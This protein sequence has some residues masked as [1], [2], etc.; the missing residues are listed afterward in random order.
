M[1]ARAALAWI[2]R[3][4]VVL[5]A[6][7]G[8]APSLVEK[9]AGEPIRGSW[10]GHPKGKQI[11]RALEAIYDSGEVRAFRLIGGKVTLV[12]RRL[13]PHLARVAPGLAAERVAEIRQ[14]HTASGAHRTIATPFPAWAPAE[15][16]RAARALDE[17]E[18]RRSLGPALDPPAR[19]RARR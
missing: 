6:G 2:E 7:R 15:V 17:A 9:L 8:A 10:W 1:T 16:L 5:Q 19:G 4:G 11:F 3:Q 13:W 12:H 18:A 14:E